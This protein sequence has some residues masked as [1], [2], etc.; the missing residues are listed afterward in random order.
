MKNVNGYTLV[1]LLLFFSS[2][3][4]AQ[5]LQSS[6]T[7]EHLILNLT[8]NP[9]ES[10]AVTWRTKENT[11][12]SVQWLES[13]ASPLIALQA[14]AKE[15]KSNTVIYFDGDNDSLVFTCHSVII[16]GLYPNTT[17]LYRVGSEETWSEWLEYKTAG[18]ENEPFSFIY[19]GDIQNGMKSQWSRVIRKAFVTAP[20]TGFMVYAGDLINRA[21]NEK[22]WQEWFYAGGF[23]HA[24]IPSIMTPGNHDYDGLELDNHWRNQF[25]LP[26]NGPDMQILEETAYYVD[27]QNLRIISVDINA[28]NLDEPTE[29]VG[30]TVIWLEKVLKEN[31]KKWT[32]ITLHF[33]FYS[34][35]ANRDN[36]ELRNKFQPLVEKYKVDMVLTGHDHA[37][38]RGMK[39]IKSMTEEGEI[40]GPVYVVS[41]SGTKQYSADD[42]GWMTRKAGNTQFF[43]VISI[44]DKT[45]N[46]KTYMATGELYDE[47][48]LIK[49]KG[50][51]NKLVD[52]IPDVPERLYTR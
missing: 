23:I 8:E 32:I 46:F 2:I 17:Y 18:Y 12:Q 51:T 9:S 27:Y 45:L 41:V 44:T 1:V 14:Q 34:T 29:A 25:T 47:F 48:D 31:K 13:T 26:E 7:P 30:R 28:D 49:R 33:P 42:K 35:K 6:S 40:S 19:F 16:D 24:S 50:K 37:Y 20:N 5:E 15:A 4:C 43:Q 36:A 52:K 21:N 11:K 39:N 38:G 3:L 10:V 22:D